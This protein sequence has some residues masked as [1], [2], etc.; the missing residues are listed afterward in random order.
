MLGV[1]QFPTQFLPEGGIMPEPFDK[2]F[3]DGGFLIRSRSCTFRRGSSGETAPEDATR[4][5][6]ILKEITTF[7]I[8]ST[9]SIYSL[10]ST[11]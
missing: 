1:R 2:L 4:N 8:V 7:H 3:D 5:E 6:R 10:P 9:Y 11:R